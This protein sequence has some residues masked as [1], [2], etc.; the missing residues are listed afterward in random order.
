MSAMSHNAA[1]AAAA[2]ALS[3]GQNA[4]KAF[5]EGATSVFRQWTALELSV[6]N[7]WGGGNSAAKVE[8]IKDHILGLFITMASSTAEKHKIYKDVSYT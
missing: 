3:V 5:I 8:A 7:S 4:L 6:F 1:A 2:P